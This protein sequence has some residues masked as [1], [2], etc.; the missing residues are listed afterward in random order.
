[1]NGINGN[2]QLDTFNNSINILTGN[3]QR[4][5]FLNHS[6]AKPGR[7][8][9]ENLSTTHGITIENYGKIVTTGL[10]MASMGP[11]IITANSPLAIGANSKLTALDDV[12]LYAGDGRQ[13]ND[14]LTISGDITSQRGNIEFTARSVNG[15]N[16][17]FA[18][19]G[20]IL[21]NGQLLNIVQ[22]PDDS[23]VIIAPQGKPNQPNPFNQQDR[24]IVLTQQSPLLTG[25]SSSDPEHIRD[26][27]KASEA[28]TASHT[29]DDEQQSS[30]NSMNVCR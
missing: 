9:V 17:L 10:V 20:N 23:G 13:D 11:M 8:D 14:I 21:F 15:L 7:L 3:T 27:K 1:M 2:Y 22:S 30:E 12:I 19:Q 26:V 16:H 29:K 5:V 25:H 24:I 4:I 6:L 28:T 18:N